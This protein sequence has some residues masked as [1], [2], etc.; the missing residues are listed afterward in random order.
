MYFYFL[1]VLFCCSKHNL[2]PINE[3]CTKVHW[4]CVACW[5]RTAFTEHEHAFRKMTLR[6]KH[7]VHRTR[8][9]HNNVR[10]IHGRTL[11]EHNIVRTGVPEH[12]HEH[13]SEHEHE[14]NTT[15]DTSMG[16]ADTE[17]DMPHLG[18]ALERWRVRCRR[19]ARPK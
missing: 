16:E 6:T 7:Y 14:H 15:S 10:T 17:L 3:G 9:E 18:F 1:L 13:E 2:T 19:R 8:P 4:V 12:E 5:T 11:S